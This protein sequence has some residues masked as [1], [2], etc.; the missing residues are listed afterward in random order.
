MSFSIMILPLIFNFSNPSGHLVS[1]VYDLILHFLRAHQILI[2][3]VDLAV[4]IFDWLLVEGA[5]WI[6]QF[7]VLLVLLKAN[8]VFNGISWL[9]LLDSGVVS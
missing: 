1:L 2:N 9:N 5:V 7:L 6:H 8:L 4:M 3:V